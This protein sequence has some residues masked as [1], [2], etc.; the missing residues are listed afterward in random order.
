MGMGV[1]MVREMGQGN[2]SGNGNRV[3]MDGDGVG[4]GG[5]QMAVGVRMRMGWRLNGMEGGWNGVET[6]MRMGLEMG[7]AQGQGWN[8]SGNGDCMW[9]GPRMG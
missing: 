7:C 3:E 8:R 6:E 4:V 5:E 2:R 9:T 1:R